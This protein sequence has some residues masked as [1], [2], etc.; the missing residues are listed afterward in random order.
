MPCCVLRSEIDVRSGGK[1]RDVACP[2][3]IGERSRVRGRGADLKVGSRSVT[4]IHQPPT[5]AVRESRERVTRALVAVDDRSIRKIGRTRESVI[6][7][8]APGM[9]SNPIDRAT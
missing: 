7:L 4:K 1:N 2:D 5:N 8:T 3:A 6:I 9:R